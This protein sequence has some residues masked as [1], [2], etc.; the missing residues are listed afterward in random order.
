MVAVS[1]SS[2]GK[3][4]ATYCL[5]EN[6][7]KIWQPSSGLFGALVGAFGGVGMPGGNTSHSSGLASLKM[8]RSFNIGSPLGKNRSYLIRYSFLM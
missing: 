7:V 8:F 6:S 3:L 5:E 4:L 1:F 2:D